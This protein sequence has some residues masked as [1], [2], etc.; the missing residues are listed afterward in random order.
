MTTL[1]FLEHHEGALQK[2]SLGV[3]SRAVA[4]GGDVA[5]VV[6]GSGVAGVAASAGAYGASTVYVV[7]DP[8]FEVPLPQPRV[9]ALEAVVA[10]AGAEG[11]RGRRDIAHAVPDD[12]AGDV[13]AERGRLAEHAE[14]ALRQPALVVLE[15][16]ERAHSSFLPASQSTS[17]SAAEPSSSILI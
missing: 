2:G 7:D 3:L 16:D 13:P 12:D 11:A 1:V 5:G 8:A 6:V 15:E 9:D 10:Q 4:L 14:G 17:C